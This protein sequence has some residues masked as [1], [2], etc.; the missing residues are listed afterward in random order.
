MRRCYGFA[1]VVGLVW[2]AGLQPAQYAQAPESSGTVIQSSVREVVLDVVVRHKSMSLA[3]KLKATDFTVTEDGAPQTI[4][5]FR[6]V[7]G[8]IARAIDQGPKPQAVGPAAKIAADQAN[9]TRA[10][11]FVSIVFDQIGADS[12]KNALDAAM[13]FLDQEFQDNTYAA[14]FRMNLRLNAI[15]G[16]SNDRVGLKES[17][18]RALNGSAT[19]LASDSANV[20]NQTD[21]T[22][23]GG[24][25]GIAVNS[26]IDLTRTPDFG[27]GPASSNPLSESQQAV[28]GM[29][30]N[31]RGMVNYGTGMAV[32][33]ALLQIIRYESI[34]P[35]R[36]TILY[37]SDGLINPP[38]NHDFVQSVI[39][40]ANRGN[41]TFYC[42]D[43][44][45][46]TTATSN[47]TTAGLT[48][49]AAVLARAKAQCRTRRR[50]RWHRRGN[51]M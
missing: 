48:A 11:N 20:L 15:H 21:Y 43:V 9:S 51:S 47:G 37:L 33:N 40:A 22:I 27:L 34:L 19:Q 36:K 6:F 32:W 30:A 49:T 38:G 35:G 41:V 1:A 5:S 7:G 46:L 23:S 45:G 12:R 26:G 10:R 17:V 13:D 24:Q 2:L 44:R 14:I 50:L 16:F 28:A 31:Q 8:K 39:S 18:R 3:D 4:K 42:I 29:I 25:G